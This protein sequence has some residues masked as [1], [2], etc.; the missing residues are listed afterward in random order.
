MF[1]SMYILCIYYCSMTTIQ[2][3]GNSIGVRIPKEIARKRSLREG[4]VVEVV[5]IPEG[6]LV[7]EVSLKKRVRLSDLLKGVTDENLHD[8]LA[9]DD[10]RGNEVW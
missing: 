9:W 6:I 3:W 4:S 7:R 10:P 1:D 8:E 2:K 5:D